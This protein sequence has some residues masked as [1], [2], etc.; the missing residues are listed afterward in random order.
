MIIS[1]PS[2]L[3]SLRSNIR[4][5]FIETSC[6]FYVEICGWIWEG[7]GGGFLYFDVETTDVSRTHLDFQAIFKEKF[8]ICNIARVVTWVNHKNWKWNLIINRY[9]VFIN[10][11]I[12]KVNILNET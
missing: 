5:Y 4:P 8:L 3:C 1:F 6:F 12:V 7:W 9:L 10:I 11:L 2:L